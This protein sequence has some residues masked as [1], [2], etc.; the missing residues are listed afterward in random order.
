MRSNRMYCPMKV[1]HVAQTAQGG[2]GSYLEEIVP[3]QAQLYGENAVRVVLPDTHA[4]LIP[5]LKTTWLAPFQ[6]GGGGRIGSS[7]RMVDQAMR[8]VLKWH[9]TVVHLHS[10]FAGVAMRPLLALLPNRPQIVYCAHG[11]AFERKV[12]SLQIRAIAHV[13]RA[14]AH[15]CDSIVCVSRFEAG[16]AREIG[17]APSLLAVVPNGVS[18]VTTDATSISD[19]AREWPQGHLRLLFV[20]R[21]DRQKGIDV[22]YEALRKLGDR[23]FGLVVGSSVL[24]DESPPPPPANARILGWRSRPEIASLYAAADVLVMPSRWEG[25]PLVAL[26]AMRAGLPVIATRVSGIPEAV[27]DGITGKLIDVDSAMQLAAVLAALD[28]PTLRRMSIN[29]RRRYLQSFQIERVVHELDQVYR[30]LAPA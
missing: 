9:P 28:A 21:L 19:A 8:Q 7:S 11:W 5:G 3:R 10:T 27:E 13:E 4:R 25:L 12:G 15:V 30:D 24:G 18:D 14:L 22:F 16:R 1:L 6:N 17:I 2:I 23:V 26:E 20:G 29:A